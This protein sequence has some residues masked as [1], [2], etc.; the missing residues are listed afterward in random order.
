M[1]GIDFIL[2]KWFELMLNQSYLNQRGGGKKTR[3]KLG[4]VCPLFSSSLHD[5]I[6]VSFCPKVIKS[7]DVL[8]L[9]L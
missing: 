8:F 4:R 5:V 3:S 7:T 2:S 9:F 6:S 1:E